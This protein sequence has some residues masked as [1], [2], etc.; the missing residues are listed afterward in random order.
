VLASVE[1]AVRSLPG[2]VKGALS[3]CGGTNRDGRRF[4]GNLLGPVSD[5]EFLG[6]LHALIFRNAVR[7]TTDSGRNRSVVERVLASPA[8]QAFPPE[9]ALRVLD[10]GASAGLDA[11]ATRA[12][13][14]ARHTVASYVLADL[15]T[16]VLY[17]RRRGLVFDMDRN[18]LQVK[19]GRRFVAVNF[20]YNYGFQRVTNVPKQLRP[21]LL[22][23]RYA[24]DPAS[25]VVT[26]PLV[27]P[28]VRVTGEAPPFE[29]RRLDVFSPI[30]GE[31]DF[32]LCMHLLVPRY[33]SPAVIARGTENLLGALAVGGLLVVGAAEDYRVLVRR[34]E[35]VEEIEV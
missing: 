20:A 31:F 14:A 25:D 7:K 23:R 22:R 4:A 30:S 15:H 33:F 1:K 3:N 21:W 11:L 6:I 5:D 29:L 9:R 2:A 34:A 18:L 10:V 35:G 13:I 12:A 16:H 32:I 27:H 24:F 8:F 19:R 28:S 26:I 17:D